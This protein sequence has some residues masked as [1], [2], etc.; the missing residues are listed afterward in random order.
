MNKLLVPAIIV[1]VLSSCQGIFS[2][3]VSGNGNITS[4]SRNAGNYKNIDVSGNIDLVVKQENAN[5]IKVQ[6]DDNLQEYIVVET[7]G[8]TLRIHPKDGFNID[9]SK[10]IKVFVSAPS[11]NSFEASGACDIT[12]DGQVTADNMMS[13]N[14]SGAC[15]IN[16][17]VKCQKVKVECSGSSDVNLKGQTKDFDVSGSGSS[18]VKAFDLMAENV[19]IDISGAGDAQVYASVSLDVEVSGS[20]DVKYKGNATTKQQVS[21]SGSVTKVN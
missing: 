16:V 10:D 5:A 14:L 6:T 11:F 20:G 2:A 7:D 8:S 1:L 13:F 18:D 9:P 3:R 15:G 17:D 4:Q 12:S 19:K 21:G